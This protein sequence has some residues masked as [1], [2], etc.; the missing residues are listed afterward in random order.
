MVVQSART[1][2]FG[3]IAHP[4]FPQEALET[5]KHIQIQQLRQ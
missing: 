1:A 2:I 5:I 4:P 3:G